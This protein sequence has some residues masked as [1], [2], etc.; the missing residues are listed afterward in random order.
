M[1]YLNYEIDQ[2]P[3]ERKKRFGKLAT[4]DGTFENFVTQSLAFQMEL[5]YS[6]E[7]TFLQIL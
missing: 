3:Y 4:N 5:S 2:K 7:K 1:E 6:S